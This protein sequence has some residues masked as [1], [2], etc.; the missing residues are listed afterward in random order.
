MPHIAWERE[1]WHNL[2]LT[3][4]FSLGLDKHEKGDGLHAGSLST[5][6]YDQKIEKHWE[7]GGGISNK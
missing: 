4:L 5:T 6:G 2:S 1:I 7:T 3:L